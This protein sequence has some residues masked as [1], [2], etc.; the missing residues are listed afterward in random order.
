[1]FYEMVTDR[2]AFWGATVDEVC[3]NILETIPD[4]PIQLNPKI[5][6]GLSDLIM[7]ALAKDPAQ[8]YA[9]G[10]ALL[11]DLE[12]C[13]D[14]RSQTAAKPAAPAK[15]VVIPENVRAAA[16]SKFVAGTPPK[17]NPATPPRPVGD[18]RAKPRHTGGE[19]HPPKAGTTR[20]K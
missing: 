4:L 13:K 18:F 7:K 6:P 5:H 8:R 3:Q 16:A 11:E 17:P 20:A 9:N 2:K 19:S 10:R 15:T 12:K 1:M 14:S